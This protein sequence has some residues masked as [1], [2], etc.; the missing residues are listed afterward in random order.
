M[1]YLGI[2]GNKTHQCYLRCV[3]TL[4]DILEGYNNQAIMAS[5]FKELIEVLHDPELPYSKVNAI[6]SMLAGRI[7]FKLKDTIRTTINAA[8]SK[9]NA[10]KFPVVCIKKVVD[11]RALHLG[12]D[13]SPQS[14]H[15]PHTTQHAVQCS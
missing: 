6:L 8:K 11:S 9:G 7:L 13:S 1:G 4:D 5:T 3:G 2:I 10:H 14:C 12:F 15:V